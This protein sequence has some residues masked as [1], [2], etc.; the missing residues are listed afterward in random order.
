MSPNNLLLQFKSSLNLNPQIVSRFKQSAL[1]TRQLYDHLS[2]SQL[3]SSTI[4][5]DPE[6]D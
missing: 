2:T 5:V 3:I 4:K 6:S 1:P